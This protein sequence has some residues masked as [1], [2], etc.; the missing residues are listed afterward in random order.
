MHGPIV[1]SPSLVGRKFPKIQKRLSGIVSY[2]LNLLPARIWNHV[3]TDSN[4]ADCA[5][6]GLLP[7]DLLEHSLWWN[8]PSWL[9]VEP[10]QWPPQ[11]VSSPLS[12]SELK[13]CACN[14]APLTSPEWIE[15][16]STNV[17]SVSTPRSC[18]SSVFS[19]HASFTNP[20]NV[21]ALYLSLSYMH[22]SFIYSLWLTTDTS[23]MNDAGCLSESH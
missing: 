12:T 11:P 13:A 6:R 23:P 3:P 15:E 1:P 19:E 16:K 22:P 10:P 21:L 17:S 9:Q 4:P 14:I 18:D 5:S 20:L 8:G 7:K 2:I